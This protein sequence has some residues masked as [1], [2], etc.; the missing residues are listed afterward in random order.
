MGTLL[1]GLPNETDD[2]IYMTIELM[3]RL[4]DLNII[5]VPCFFTPLGPTPLGNSKPLTR[6]RMRKS[7]WELLA[8]CCRYNAKMI[9][10]FAENYFKTSKMNFIKRYVYLR[11]LKLMKKAFEE[12]DREIRNGQIP[13]PIL[14]GDIK[15][16]YKILFSVKD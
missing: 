13:P 7:H 4:K 6:D 1:V 12:I 15:T 11:G 9:E 5:W 8:T 16:F 2:D 3:D 14:S 10:R